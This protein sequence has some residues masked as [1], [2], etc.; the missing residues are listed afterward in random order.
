MQENAVDVYQA[1]AVAQISDL[2]LVPDFFDDGLWH[3]YP[4]ALLL[5]RE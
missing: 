4:D 5:Q 2:M 3:G 1:G